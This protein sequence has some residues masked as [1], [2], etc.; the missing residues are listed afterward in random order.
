MIKGYMES[1]LTQSEVFTGIKDELGVVD[2]L[3]IV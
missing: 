2:K 1:S 3:M